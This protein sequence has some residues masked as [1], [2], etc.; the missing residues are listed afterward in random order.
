MDLGKTKAILKGLSALPELNVELIDDYM[1]FGYIPGEKTLH[2]GINRLMPGH[3]AI[4]KGHE[5]KITQWWDLTFNNDEDKG[6]D[7]YL[8]ENF[9]CI[10]VD[11]E[12]RPD[13]DQFYQNIH[14][15][16]TNKAGGWPCSIFLT[17]DKTPFYAA[18]Y[19]PPEPKYNIIQIVP[20]V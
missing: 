13:I 16:L 5:M 15:V 19:I 14:E 20:I 12:E 1:S 6:F 4:V 2:K 18:T 11:R 9:V 3:Y 17:P 7:Y 10:K 8:N